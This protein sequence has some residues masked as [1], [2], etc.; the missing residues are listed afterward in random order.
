MKGGPL[1]QA[2]DIEIPP[3]RT[4]RKPSS[5]YPRRTGA[6][7]SPSA[8][9]IEEKTSKSSSPLSTCKKAMDI[10]NNASW[11]VRKFAF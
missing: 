11:K 8:E 1:G 7:F 10:E 3:P 5:P 9:A 4:K 2:H 6:G